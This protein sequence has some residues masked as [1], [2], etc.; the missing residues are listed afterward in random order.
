ML[1]MSQGKYKKGKIRTS[2]GKKCQNEQKEEKMWGENET[3]FKR[4]KT[5]TMKHTERKP[6]GKWKER[7]DSEQKSQRN[8]IVAEYN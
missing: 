2:N 3:K 5:F 4:G 1:L 6:R 8:R 7:V